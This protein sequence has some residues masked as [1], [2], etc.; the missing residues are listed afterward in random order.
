MALDA[1][2]AAAA[3]RVQR[4]EDDVALFFDELAYQRFLPGDQGGRR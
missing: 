3:H 4:L 1:E 2:H